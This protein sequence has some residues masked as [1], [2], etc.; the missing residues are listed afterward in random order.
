[1][2]ADYLTQ[3]NALAAEKV[4]RWAKYANAANNGIKLRRE[5]H[6]S[7]AMPP[8]VNHVRTEYH[9]DADGNPIPAMLGPQEL[10]DRHGLHIELVYHKGLPK[11]YWDLIG[12]QG[13]DG[14]WLYGTFETY[15][16]ALAEANRIAGGA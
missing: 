12:E 8:A 4:W 3:C 1:M 10:W 7:F 2:N 13:S 15:A 5:D 14:R 9:G 6:P 11:D 16:A